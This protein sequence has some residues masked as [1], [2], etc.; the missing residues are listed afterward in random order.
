MK[1]ENIIDMMKAD[2]GIKTIS[3]FMA[4]DSVIRVSRSINPRKGKSRAKPQSETFLVTLGKPN[5]DARQFIK[6]CIKAGEPFPVK[7]PQ[8]KRYPIKGKTNV[9]KS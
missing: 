2:K 3:K 5:Y 6:L 1:I 4:R 9:S 7:R 8:I